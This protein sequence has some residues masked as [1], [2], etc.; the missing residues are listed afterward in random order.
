MVISVASDDYATIY[1]N[2]VLIDSDVV[3]HHEAAYW[4]RQV[5]IPVNLINSNGDN[6]VAVQVKNADQWGFFDAQ[7]SARYKEIGK[8]PTAI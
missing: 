1:F 8:M 4:N 5:F 3:I 7:V 2:G 6:L